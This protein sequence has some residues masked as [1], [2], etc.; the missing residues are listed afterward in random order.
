MDCPDCKTKESLVEFCVEV[1]YCHISLDGP[2]LVAAL[3]RTVKNS[4]YHLE[5]LECEKRFDYHDI[6]G[7]WI[8]KI[9]Y[10]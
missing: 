10:E 6:T 2:K 3:P 5:C 8:S 9:E 7:E 4:T 1:S